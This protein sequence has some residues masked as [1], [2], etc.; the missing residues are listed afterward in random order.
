VLLNFS[1]EP[2]EFAFNIPAEIG[3]ASG[4]S[5]YDLLAEETVPAVAEG[6]IR[7]SVPGLRARLLT[8]T[9]SP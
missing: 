7:V 8:K 9:P 1:E 3:P 5:L 4:E 6:R 2:A